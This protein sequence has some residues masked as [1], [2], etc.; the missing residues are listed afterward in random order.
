MTVKLWLRR[1]ERWR[2]RARRRRALRN[3]RLL[4]HGNGQSDRY[5]P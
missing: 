4:E 2:Q 1:R 5:A 3:K